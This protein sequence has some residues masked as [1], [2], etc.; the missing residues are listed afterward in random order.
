MLFKAGDQPVAPTLRDSPQDMVTSPGATA[1]IFALSVDSTLRHPR[2]RGNPVE[3][4]VPAN[5]LIRRPW[6][7]LRTEMRAAL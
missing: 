4:A 1:T 3:R 5:F 6:A 2:E 7:A